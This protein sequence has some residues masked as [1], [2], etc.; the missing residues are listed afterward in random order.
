MSR[1]G[2]EMTWMKD[3]GHGGG[4]LLLEL[5][6]ISLG[7]LVSPSFHRYERLSKYICITRLKCD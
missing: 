6:S 2:I 7:S 1:F 5:K 4:V 3:G